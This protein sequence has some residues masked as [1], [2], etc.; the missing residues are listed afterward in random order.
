LKTVWKDVFDWAFGY[1]LVG[2]CLAE[3]VH[4][5]IERV[6]W[7]F[8]IALVPV[9]YMVYRSYRVYM[10]RME[11]EKK[12]VE[13]TAALHMRT[14]E[15][16]AM[17]IEAKDA[18]TH[19]H[20]CRVQV[21]S[22]KI[23][24]YLGLPEQEVRA[25]HAASILH[26]IGKLAVPDYII[27]KP[28]KLTA[29]EFEKMKIHTVVGASILDQVGFP[30]PVAPIVRSHH[31]KW[32]GSGYPD[33][34]KGEEI[35]IGA[36]ILAAVDCLDALASD[37]QYRRAMPLDEAMD[38]VASLA[39]HSFDPKVIE[40]LKERYREL[41]TLA[42]RS[43]VHVARVDRNIARS[44]AA[45]EAGLQVESAPGADSND[46]LPAFISPIASARHEVQTI[47]ELTQDLSGSL[48]L[49]EM[50]LLVGER[51]KRL[52]PFDCIAVY[53]RDGAVLKARYVYG[54]SSR[55]FRRADMAI[56][57][58]VSGWVAEN[59]KP[60]LN[61][62]PAV[63][64]GYDDN[65]G[66][67]G[68]LR[69]AISVPL[70][71]PASQVQG[72]LTL[73]HAEASAYNRD[74]VRLLL[75]VVDKISR[76]LESA[77]RFQ[78]AKHEANTDELT[79]LPNARSLFMRLENEISRCGAEDRRLAVMVCDLDGFKSVNDNF[80]HL[81]G[82]ELLRRVARILVEN[83]RETDYVSRMGGDEFVAILAGVRPE[84]LEAKIASFDALIRAAS[85]EVCGHE[86]VGVSAGISY[87]PDDGTNA[88]QLLSEAD[89]EMYDAKRSRKM[90]SS[91]AAGLS[92]KVRPFR[93]TNGGRV[94]IA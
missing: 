52:V 80:G 72:A 84:E 78:E 34:L 57:Q 61:G 31:E 60:M 70:G 81:A 2:V 26:D 47:L 49:E 68:C 48:R 19:D 4:L 13:S 89:R 64:P 24:Q 56:G 71:G 23:A 15:A 37:R 65:A 58:G 27:S 85:V 73:Y 88:E 16:L 9:L 42:T 87:Y 77:I 43:A 92:G 76:A 62:N 12:H 3:M 14:I 51:L 86:I 28:G 7:T 44:E 1:Y 40:V 6:G 32:D 93:R 18:C 53:I 67:F 5:S 17:A 33:G 90:N 91:G 50:L 79:G 66:A 83:C 63:E 38:Y 8:T 36:R 21:Y 82:N 35:P 74:H 25:L 54:D 29:E 39:G 10:E 94:A 59:G 30:Y 69:S 75:A 11:Q 20:L 45:P 46:A 41:E 55:L 22:L